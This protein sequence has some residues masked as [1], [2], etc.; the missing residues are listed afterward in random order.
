MRKYG[1]A[2]ASLLMLLLA[3]PAFAQKIT[4]TLRGEVTDPTGGV[5]SGA[6]VTVTN[7]DTGLTRS[8][9]TT[10]A[11]IY[12][13]SDLPVGSYKIQV[14]SQGFKS[15]VRSKIALNV[16]DA[17]AVD[18][19]LQ[20][21]D[22]SEVVDVEVAAV[23]VKTVG[24]DVS[25][26]VT[27]TEARALPLNGRNFMQ[28]TLLQPGVSGVDGFNTVDKGLAGGSDVSVSGGSTTSNLWT[29]D[30]ANNNDVGSNRTILVYPSVDTIEEFKI[31]R[32]NYGA[33]FGQAGG[34][35]VNLVTRGGTNDFHGSGYYYL[36]RDK[37]NSTDYFLEQA[38]RENP[39]LKWDDFGGTIGGPIVKDKVHF[40]F[41]MEWNKDRR[42]DV[43]QAFVPT[44]AERNGDFS[45]PG[46]AGCS[47]PKPIDP[48]TG[49]P[50]PGN[51][52]P[53]NRISPGGRAMMAL[54]ALPNATPTGGSCNN[55]L[56]A[57]PTPVDWRQESARV[58]W[59]I[60][61]STRLM[62]RWTHDSW[63]ADR[64][65]WG[66]DPFPTVRSL[67]NQPGRSLVT[68]LNHNIGSSMVNSLTFSY[69]A[70]KIEVTRAGDEDLIQQLTAGIPTVFPADIKQQG[71]QGQPGAMWGSL[72]A[73]GG[74]I[75]WNQ[76]PWLN[77]QDLF[78][79]KDDYS[80]VFGKH[81]IKAGVLL[82]YNK[83]NEEP[84]NTTQ[85]SV[86]VN[87]PAG[88]IGPGGFLN[89]V[90]TGNEIANWLLASTVWNTAEIRTNKS[91][92]QRWKD[93]EGYI[94]D[95]IKMSSR[96]TTDVGVRF[97][98]F[99][100]PFMADDQM[101]TF[102]PGSVNPAFGNS[103]CNGLLYVPGQN[104]CPALGLAGG[105]DGPNRSLQPTKA[106]LVAPRLGV[107]WDVFGTGK[108]AVR[109]G[110]GLFYARERL[111]SGL[112]L[113][114]NPPFSGT[115]SVIRTLASN[116]PVSG[117]AV[118]AFGAPAAGIIQEAGNG[119]NWQ[120]NLAVQ[121]ELMRNT[122]LEVAYV[123][124]KGQDLLGQT[125]LNEIPV[126]N[127]LAYSQTGNVALRPLN[128]IAGIGDGNPTLTTRDR[129]SIYHALQTQLVSR[130]GQGSLLSLS[131]TWAKSIADTGIGN[132]DGPGISQRNAYTDSTQPGLD[133]ARS[134]VD[135][136]HVFNGT[137]VL[138]LPKLDDKSSAVKNVFGNWEVSSIV[139]AS[140]GFPYTIFLGAVPGLSG[141]GNLAG[142]G[143]SGNQ[144]PD[145][146]PG[147][148]CTLNDSSAP[149][150]WF[151]PAAFTINGHQIGTNGD[152]GRHV[153]DGPGF[154]RVD[155]SLTKNIKL[156]KTVTLQF[157][158][159]MFN[160]F[161]RVNFI[162]DD[163]NVNVTW[164]PNN[165]VFNTGNA[166]TATSIV[167]ATPQGGFGQ[168]NRAADPRQMQ[169]GVRLSF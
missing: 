113:G 7:E 3:V 81:F 14:E 153:C 120:W 133:R 86:Q 61:N 41:S 25:G 159:E 143:Y 11:G 160:V 37:F 118:P 30:G 132:A 17:R 121:H 102:D 65:Q 62:V 95:T 59:S 89:G 29:V 74:G 20:T 50:F 67:W 112:A 42:S 109:G 115:A 166:A 144:R 21:G 108:T 23:A 1:L 63:K 156:G 125:N 104:P 97:T 123:G 53:Q 167:S 73:Y 34:A 9:T 47:P 140:S 117:N 44:E 55:W 145:R 90:T 58:D 92:L 135:K 33:E 100:L 52:I 149:T 2:I 87:G 36:R 146:V 72:G 151:N 70:N 60:T 134:A 124:N 39:E 13:F 76:A 155:A 68:Q 66:D 103:P 19:Q 162:S 84:A 110:L 27:G 16:A 150:Q 24:A 91:V 51:I 83:K 154:F 5:I 31:Q 57:V 4:G 15:E 168:L 10:S 116:Q 126:A 93:Y 138:A 69:S 147:V 106:V 75:L 80:A 141:N 158:A 99:T 152:S 18:V 12:V 54:M 101:A 45:G 85:E 119:N 40:F 64:N 139:Q 77:N 111:S 148:S 82:S 169:F 130:F 128:G 78:V 127:R 49:Q 122:V 56:E 43:R 136:A 137:L 71:G 142:T 94:A 48:L 8:G 164:T 22:I 131:Y 26:L 35:Q 79:L 163:G 129:S 46:L 96:V 105:G 114:Q 6:K 107:A 161:N 88:S 28:L 98:H 165:V 38:G 32:N 157:R